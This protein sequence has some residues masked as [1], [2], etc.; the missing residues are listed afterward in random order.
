MADNTVRFI[1]L[2]NAISYGREK[3]Y[4]IIKLRYRHGNFF[5]QFIDNGIGIPSSDK[6]R[7][8]ERFYRGDHSRSDRER[9]GLGLSIAQE[10][11]K[12]HHGK[13]SV[14]DTPGGGA[15]FTVTLPG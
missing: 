15:T 4:I 3:G 10:I 7:I 1:L 8:F 13:I 6:E 2:S 11:I 9:F 5:L 12:A 14:C